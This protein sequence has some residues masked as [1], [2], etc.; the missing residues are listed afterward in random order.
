MDRK[1]KLPMETGFERTACELKGRES[2]VAE[3]KASCGR[4]CGLVSHVF[5]DFL[6]YC[7]L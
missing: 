7:E 5:C 6:F 4:V 3:K 1:C 2:S